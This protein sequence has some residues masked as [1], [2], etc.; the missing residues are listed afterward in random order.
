MKVNE[1]VTR[2]K[3]QK[4]ILACVYGVPGVGKTTFASNAPRPLVWC[5]EQGANQIDVDK[6]DAPRM[7]EDVLTTIRALIDDTGH[8][9]Q[10]LVID[11]L[12]AMEELCVT[13]V[14]RLAK[15]D[16]L[17]DFDFGKGQQAVAAQWR[18]ALKGFELLRDQR[19]MNIILVAHE[20]RKPMKDPIYGEFDTYRPKLIER[21]WNITNEWCDCVLFADFDRAPLEKKGE[22]KRVMLSGSRVL[23]TTRDTG[24]LAKTRF[25]LPKILPL[26]WDTFSAAVFQ[27][28]SQLVADLCATLEKSL[29]DLGDEA[30]A[31][32]A[33][34]HVNRAGNTAASY[35]EAINTVTTYLNE[36]AA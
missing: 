14:C 29:D 7:W 1:L 8:Q 6:L 30:I 11:T 23:R 32:K 9:Y 35:R 3:K 13:Y 26:D 25:P 28:Q 27:D 22:M 17:A 15:K 16:T 5:F 20:H 4:P 19:G 36:R 34:E 21:V 18:I 10:T 33:K 12:D 2:G 24:F 31:L